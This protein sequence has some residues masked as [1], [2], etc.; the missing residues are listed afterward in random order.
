MTH[1]DTKLVFSFK[2]YI[3]KYQKTGLAPLFF[4]GVVFLFLDIRMAQK[5]STG[6]AM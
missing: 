1:S 5:W 3:I 2:M 4:V 6:D